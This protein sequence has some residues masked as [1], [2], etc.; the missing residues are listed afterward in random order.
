MNDKMSERWIM[1]LLVTR[2]P[3]NDKPPTEW[4]WS[5]DGADVVVMSG[6]V[7]GLNAPVPADAPLQKVCARCHQPVGEHHLV[8]CLHWPAKVNLAHAE[9]A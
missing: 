8:A 9:R 7:I 6:E 3:I 2:D 1:R 5:V 4:D